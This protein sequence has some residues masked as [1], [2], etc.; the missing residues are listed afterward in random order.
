[1]NEV[2]V[3]VLKAAAIGICGLTIVDD[4]RRRFKNANRAKRMALVNMIKLR[5]HREQSVVDGKIIDGL[6]ESNRQLLMEN[7][8]LRDSK[9]K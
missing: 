2:T 6:M 3:K 5:Q 7:H 9:K 8:E 1:M 4:V